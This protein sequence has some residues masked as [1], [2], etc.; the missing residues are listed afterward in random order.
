MQCAEENFLRVFPALLLAIDVAQIGE[1]H[2]IFRGKLESALK[3]LDGFGGAVVAS[4]NDAEIVPGFFPGARIVGAKLN[5]AFEIATR[6]R[7]ILLLEIDAAE[8]VERFGARGIVAKCLLEV[9][10][11]VQRIATLE[12]GGA[13]RKIV[14]RKI[15]RVE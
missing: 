8:A 14:A 11:G 15:E 3:V 10:L 4:G 12:E 7:E 5:G 13:E 6:F 1:G 2:R 9:R